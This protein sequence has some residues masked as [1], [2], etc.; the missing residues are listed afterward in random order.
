MA[1]KKCRHENIIV[2]PIE[3]RGLGSKG[4][5]DFRELLGYTIYCL[6]CKKQVARYSKHDAIEA[7][8]QD[9]LW[10]NSEEE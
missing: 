10:Q 2:S 4:L 7:I 1:R 3:E 8:K 6:S 9:F 5:N